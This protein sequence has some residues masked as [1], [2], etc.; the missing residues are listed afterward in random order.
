MI[1]Q[2]MKKTNRYCEKK[3]THTQCELIVTILEAWNN[4]KKKKKWIAPDLK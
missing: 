1:L 2:L 3:N 4:L